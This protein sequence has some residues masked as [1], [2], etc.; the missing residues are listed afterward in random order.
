MLA[1]AQHLRNEAEAEGVSPESLQRFD[2]AFA[3]LKS[4]MPK[5]GWW[6]PNQP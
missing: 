6:P 4:R 2:E 5:D 3:R 1:S